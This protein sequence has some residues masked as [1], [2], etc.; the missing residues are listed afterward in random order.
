MFLKEGRK[1][2]RKEG[3]KERRK[4][5]K[6]EGRREGRKE[7][8]KERIKNLKKER[9]IGK[10]GGSFSAKDSATRQLAK[11]VPLDIATFHLH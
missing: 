4:E 10:S 2:R 1:E 5:G 3:R 6:K 8:K 11:F 9:T 7:R